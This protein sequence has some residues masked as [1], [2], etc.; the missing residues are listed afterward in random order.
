MSEKI[1]RDTKIQMGI[2]KSRGLVVKN[3]KKAKDIIRRTNYYNLINGYK[4][5]F[6][7]TGTV[8]EKYLPGTTIEEIYA[9][10][11]FDRKLRILTLEYILEIEKHVKSIVSYCFSKEHGHKEYLKIS[12]FDTYGSDKCTKVYNLISRLYKNI[13]EN[14]TKEPSIAHYV[15][16]K[17]YIPLWVIVNTMSIGD[18]SKFYSSMLQKERS[19]VARRIK[20]GVK[21]KELQSYLFF[22]STIRNRCAH[23]ERLFSYLSFVG[24]PQNNYLTYFKIFNA[25]SNYFVLM[26][27][28]KI[29]LP[30][31]RFRLYQE[32]LEGLQR[33]LDVHLKV[34]SSKKIRYMMGM[35]SNWKKL[36]VLQ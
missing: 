8:S 29:L 9:L 22:L 6:L 16:G 31:S 24:I 21:E 30:K 27:V 20:Y 7:Q 32:Q 5:P 19:E 10:Y 15:N 17:N 12:N 18:I 33:Q 36:K 13:S 14:I 4:E 26:T 25:K 35:P 11:E 34:I 3:R 1:F 28:F 2:L 23:D